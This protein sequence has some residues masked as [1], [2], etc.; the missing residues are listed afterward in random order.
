MVNREK[1]I[2]IMAG[3]T[4]GHIFPAM[5]IAEK[6]KSEGAKVE[7]LG[8]VDGL[9]VQLVSDQEIPLHLISVKG[10]RGQGL[11]RLLLAPLMIT[12]AII[13]AVFVMRKVKPD[14]VLGMGGFVTG[15][16]G[17][18]AKIS[19]IKLLIHEQNAVPGVTNKILSFIANKVLEAFPNTFKQ[20]H[21]VECTGNPVRESIINMSKISNKTWDSEGPIQMLVLGGSQGAVAVNEIIPAIL[22]TWKSKEV[23]CVIHQTGANNLVETLALYESLGVEPNERLQVTGFIDD[24]AKVFSWADVVICRS[25]AS[26]VCELA[27]AG[28]PSILIPYPHHKDNQQTKNAQWLSKSGAGIIIQQS[29]LTCDLLKLTLS[30]LDKDRSKLQLMAS[31]S[32]QLA[33]S[34]A[35]TIIANHCLEAASG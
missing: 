2:L 21:K 12:R 1:K 8:A 16:G 32:G 25:G 18:A 34:H 6:L 15:P 30:K 22:A 5:S 20:R 10:L 19:G 24:M 11:L 29:E 9:E 26:T 33:N 31:A 7:W 4:G 28:L 14:C 27:V 13:Q 35:S 23:P 3:G 17:V